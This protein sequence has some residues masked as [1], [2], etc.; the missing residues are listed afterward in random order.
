MPE[1]VENSVENLFKTKEYMDR[2]VGNLSFVFIVSLVRVSLYEIM[3]IN[4][5]CDVY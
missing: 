2:K 1:S 3:N 4:K 5:S